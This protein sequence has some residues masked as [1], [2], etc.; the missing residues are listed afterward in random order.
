MSG[1]WDE[2]LFGCFGDCKL[3]LL[4]YFCPC[5][6]LGYVGETV[7]KNKK[8]ACVAYFIPLLNLY[9][10]YQLRSKVKDRKGIEESRAAS[11]F[12]VLFCT[13][14]A[15]NQMARETGSGPYGES[16]ARE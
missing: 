6:V 15:L 10:L 7:G 11:I 4:Q 14:C 13:F 16:M 2:G 1:I 3:C 9:C 5:L 12:F 8:K